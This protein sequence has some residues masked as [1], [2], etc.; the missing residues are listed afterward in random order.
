MAPY[1]VDV[2]AAT[3]HSTATSYSDSSAAQRRPRK[4]FRIDEE[5]CLLR[6]VAS[7]DPYQNPAAW[8]EVLLHVVRAVQRDLTIRAIKERVDLLVGYFRQQDSIN[9]RK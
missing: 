2:L 9:L 6:E 7:A 3:N 4:R 8:E 1:T 5:L